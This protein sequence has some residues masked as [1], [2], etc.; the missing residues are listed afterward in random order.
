MK[1]LEQFNIPFVGL[2]EGSHLFDYH[3]DKKFFDAFNFEDFFD[4]DININITFVKKSTLLELSFSAN[5]TVNIPCDLT[6]EP[7]DQ[8]I[9]A[10]LP[11]V[12]KFGQE[13]N[14]DNEEILIIPHEAYQVNV[15][16]YI[17]EMIVLA[18]PSKRIHPKVI[19]GSMKSEALKKLKT[20]KINK[21]KNH[22]EIDPRWNKLKDLLTDKKT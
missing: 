2:K 8:K 15:A 19:D 13:F 11:L 5:G 16:Q 1:G 3:I 22:K 6:N 7:Y 12:I 9:E 18:V 17:Y 10:S 4:V 14:D 20:L 21:E